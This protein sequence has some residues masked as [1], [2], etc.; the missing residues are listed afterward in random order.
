MGV[1]SDDDDS[2]IESDEAFGESDDEKFDG[3]AFGGG[4]AQKKKKKKA[5]ESSGDED[6]DESDAGDDGE[7]LGSDAIDLADA[8]M[9]FI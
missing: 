1:N 9:Q 6:G 8:L 3:Y 5:D 4:Q 7:S 2:E